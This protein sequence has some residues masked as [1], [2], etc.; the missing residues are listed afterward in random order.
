MRIRPL[1]A[2]DRARILELVTAT[3]NFTAAEIDVAMEVVDEALADPAFPRGDYRAYVAEDGDGRVAGYECHGPTPLTEGTYDLYWIAVD[4]A[5][6]GAGFGRAL[7]A[8]AEADV[9]ATGGRLLL[10][11]TSS[12]ESYGATIRFY[13]KS[14]YPLAARIKG[15]Y[16]PGDDKL[17]FAKQ[18]TAG[19]ILAAPAP[20]AAPA[21][22]APGN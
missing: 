20:A 18:L 22:G 7:L 12:Q 13:E 15:Y 10:I 16:R 2:R 11:E 8:F 4:P 3:G 5:F 19:E 14:G 6:Q 9:R 17:I 1:A 21:A